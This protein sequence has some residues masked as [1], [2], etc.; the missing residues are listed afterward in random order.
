M[1]SDTK[2]ATSGWAGPGAYE[3]DEV[4]TDDD[5]HDVPVDP[6][7]VAAAAGSDINNRGVAKVINAKGVR[8]RGISVR[9]PDRLSPMFKIGSTGFIPQSQTRV[10]GFAA[11]PVTS[12]GAAGS[13]GEV[14]GEDEEEGGELSVGGSQPSPTNRKREECSKDRRR[15]PQRVRLAKQLKQGSVSFRI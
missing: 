6:A 4:P 13:R 12:R 5:D 9:D 7:A 2:R 8:P 1:C 15:R 10:R 3:W 14:E 11:V